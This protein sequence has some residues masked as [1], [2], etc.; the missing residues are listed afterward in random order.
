MLWIIISFFFLIHSLV[1]S[2][3]K[4]TSVTIE[5]LVLWILP[6]NCYIQFTNA[7][8]HLLLFIISFP[9]SQIQ[10]SMWKP[11]SIR[12]SASLC[13]MSG[14]RIRYGSSLTMHL[15]LYSYSFSYYGKRYGEVFMFY[16]FFNQQWR[17]LQ[18][19]MRTKWIQKVHSCY[20]IN[21]TI[22]M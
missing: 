1:C 13:G 16:H 15:L 9:A 19:K 17:W 8:I 5:T 18:C 11:W 22:L 14:V 12:T 2:W 7:S 21:G 6:R 3:L 4:L 20:S 10:A